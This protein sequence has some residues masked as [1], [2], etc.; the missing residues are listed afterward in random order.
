MGKTLGSCCKEIAV[1]VGQMHHMLHLWRKLGRSGYGKCKFLGQSDPAVNA[2]FVTLGCAK[3]S[4]PLG[5]ELS[6]STS[7]AQK[8]VRSCQS[9]C[10]QTAYVEY[11]GQTSAGLLPVSHTFPGFWRAI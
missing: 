3:G 1:S 11:L 9:P 2:G 8:C 6:C 7:N 5:S 4:G 10:V